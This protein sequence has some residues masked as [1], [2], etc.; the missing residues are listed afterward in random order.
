MKR[1]L[2]AFAAA[3]G[4]YLA[5]CGSGPC[6]KLQ[7]ICNKCTDQATKDTCDQDVTSFK[8]IPGGDTDCQAAID[9]GTFSSCK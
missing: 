2:L 6:D 9:D 4:L 8:A 1:A 3:G 7:S 5:G